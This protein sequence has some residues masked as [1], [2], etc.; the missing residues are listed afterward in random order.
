MSPNS[1]S[2][3]QGKW[4][5]EEC[6]Y[7]ML[8]IEHFTTGRLPGLLG[9]ESLRSTLSECLRCTPMR[10]TKKLSATHA[11]GKCCFKKSGSLDGDERSSLDGARRAFLRSVDPSA[12]AAARPRSAHS[13]SGRGLA[14]PMRETR[15]GTPK[16][17]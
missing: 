15:T 9:G 13:L 2:R 4:T 16:T 14:K 5:T 10:V 17:G 12:G 11:I 3:R 6:E 7:C 1:E 8:L